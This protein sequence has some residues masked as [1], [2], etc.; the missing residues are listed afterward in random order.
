MS[1]RNRRKMVTCGALY[2]K[3][4]A[5]VSSD[6][7]RLYWRVY[8]ASDNFGT[9]MGEAWDVKAEAAAVVQSLTEARVGKALDEL[10]EIGLLQRW[11][12]GDEIWIH[13]LGHDDH[14]SADFKRK[15]GRRRTPKPPE[16]PDDKREA[17][18]VCPKGSEGHES[19]ASTTSTST[20]SVEESTDVLL[21][22][23][24]ATNGARPASA[25]KGDEARQV[26]DHW[27]Q[28]AAPIQLADPSR[29]KLTNDRRRLIIAR[30]SDGY[31]VADLCSAVDGFAA[32]RFH[33]GENDRGTPFLDFPTIFKK[34]SKVDEGLRHAAKGT[35]GA[36]VPKIRPG[37]NL[38]AEL[39]AEQ[40]GGRA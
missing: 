31:S 10:V 4:L 6:A 1:R 20:P 19:A 33:R 11:A 39:A 7:E 37:R 17:A 36:Q 5:K 32:D 24:S 38:T 30:L 35:V 8:M 21:S 16:M 3:K 13:V 23:A 29:A 18:L 26:F 28:V 14:Q 27:V 34:A 25:K 15:R 2:S 40:A 22:A 9:M 12:V